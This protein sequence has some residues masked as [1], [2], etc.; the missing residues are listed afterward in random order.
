MPLKWR[1]RR[2]AKAKGPEQKRQFETPAKPRKAKKPKWKRRQPNKG[3]FAPGPDPRR[4]V[5]TPSDCRVGWLV[6]NCKH[7]H[8]RD[9]LKMRLRCYYHRKE[10]QHKEAALVTAPTPPTTTLE[11]AEDDIPFCQEEEASV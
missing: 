3:S 4:H 2:K 6:A 1:R 10:Q 7:P 9:W 8:M 5:F 11:Y